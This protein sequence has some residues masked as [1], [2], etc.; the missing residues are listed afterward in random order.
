MGATSMLSKL[1]RLGDM[2]VDADT[3]AAVAAVAT[4]PTAGTPWP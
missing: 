2:L 1:R 3:A 4:A